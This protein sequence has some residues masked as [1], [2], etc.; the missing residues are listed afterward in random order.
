MRTIL[1]LDITKITTVFN[2]K[3]DALKS[4]FQFAG[5]VTN[6]MLQLELVPGVFQLDY[7]SGHID[8]VN[9]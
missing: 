5:M 6:L 9:P 1:Y 4:S 8:H 7:G 2:L 3:Y